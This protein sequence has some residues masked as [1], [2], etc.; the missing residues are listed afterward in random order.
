MKCPY[1]DDSIH[2]MAKFCPK[3][4]LPLKEDA[5]LQG[6]YVVDDSGPS[7][8]VIVAGAAGIA[9][10]AL[11]IGWMSGQNKSG[12]AP[13]VDVSRL[14]PP[15]P[16]TAYALGPQMSYQPQATQWQVAPPDYNPHVR[17]A[18][19]PPPVSTAPPPYYAYQPEAPMPPS[20]MGTLKVL[21][22]RPQPVGEVGPPEPEHPAIPPLPLYVEAQTPAN[23]GAAVVG[24]GNYNG[25]SDNRQPPT[26]WQENDK[27]TYLWDPVHE[28][29]ALNS[30]RT[31]RRASG[32]VVMPRP[33]TPSSEAP[34]APDVSKTPSGL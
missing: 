9:V 21:M 32:R 34:K 26:S 20:N 18:Y 27:A 6:T 22:R 10:L 3:C 4:G 24:D 25:F 7:P 29:W 16:I 8:W 33:E 12:D 28:R 15:A 14:P 11:G 19:V 13:K 2:P 31:H 1:C 17:W 23:T 30:D 5:T